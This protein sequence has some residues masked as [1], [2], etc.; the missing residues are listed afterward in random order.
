MPRFTDHQL[1]NKALLALTEAYRL[2]EK[3]ALPKSLWL[4][5]LL[6]YL[7]RGLDERST[8][9]NFWKAAT[10]PIRG[11]G[12]NAY[13]FGRHQSLAGCHKRIYRLHGYEPPD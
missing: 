3:Q 1:L 11:G 10:Q 8:F 13:D 7:A 6:A 9:D 4:R 2:A 5:F 12:H